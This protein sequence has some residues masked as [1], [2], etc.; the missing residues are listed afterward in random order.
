M[1]INE[2][3]E[4]FF[5][6]LPF[7]P[8][9]QQVELIGA[10]SRFC[11]QLIPNE[12]VF[13]LMG[14]AG[15]GKTSVTSSLVKTL[16]E[17]RIPVALMAPTGR[18]AKVFSKMAG[19][20][21]FT[22]HRKIYQMD[23][24]G[25]WSGEIAYNPVRNGIFIIDEA[26]MIGNNDS[27]EP[28]SN[29]LADLIQYVYSGDGCKMIMLGDS[30]QLPPVGYNNSPA[31]DI[32]ILKKYGLRVSR[33]LLTEVVRQSRNSG[34]L[35]NA[36][37]MR[38][39]MLL[40]KLPPVQ[41]RATGFDDVKII[42]PIEVQENI[43]KSYT[44]VGEENT[45]IITRSN[46]RA[47]LFNQA[48]RGKI[49]G[50]EEEICKGE[51]LLIV[52]NNY[53]W[54]TNVKGLDFIANGDIGIIEHIYGSEEKYNK[55]FANVRLYF[56]DLDKELD[57]KILLDTLICD[58]PSLSLAESNDLYEAVMNDPSLFTPEMSVS[59]RFR[60]AKSNEY[61]N[62]LQVKY[63]YA[64][65]CHKAQGG[66][67]NHVYVDMGS[68]KEEFETKEFYRWI[69]TATTRATEIINFINPNCKI[70]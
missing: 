60:I 5:L 10:L 7:S 3:A 47:N 22:I 39:V 33:A 44:D 67:W 51:R 27:N 34:I 38:K 2:F 31:F 26:S 48:I 54:S 14:Y 41:I 37:W 56:P 42:E 69:Y 52:K 68:I 35:Y 65:T 25:M 49:L 36:T 45:I 30:A 13:L 62:A 32:Q 61:L 29:L 28:S 63:G 57:C 19:Y 20:K 66:Q 12:S 15:T 1:T 50:R 46:K 55:R 43:E 58:G 4:R 70:I 9:N 16:R 17:A 8:N 11:S 53:L 64:V 18:A 59:Q 23:N 21:A 24:S 40:D 6:N